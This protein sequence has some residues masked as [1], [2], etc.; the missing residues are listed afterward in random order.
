MATHLIVRVCAIAA[1]IGICSIATLAEPIRMSEKL[2]T[3]SITGRSQP[4]SA[5]VLRNQAILVS[6]VKQTS[7]TSLLFSATNTQF[8]SSGFEKR[9]TASAVALPEPSAIMLL[10]TG[11]LGALGYRARRR[12]A[13]SR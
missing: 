2:N 13:K 9:G 5:F 11:L 10:G 6:G 1:A 8:L 3:V 12:S 4:N 7:P